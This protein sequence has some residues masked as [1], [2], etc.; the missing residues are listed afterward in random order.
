MFIVLITIQKIL[1]DEDFGLLLSFCS[2]LIGRAFL[3]FMQVVYQRNIP[4]LSL[5]GS[6]GVIYPSCTINW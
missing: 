4:A 6:I 2:T 5:C 3:K 1:D